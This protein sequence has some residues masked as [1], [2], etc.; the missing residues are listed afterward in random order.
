M[1]DDNTVRQNIENE[2][3]ASPTV[4]DR[5]LLVKVRDG[6]A[7][8]GGYVPH[9]SD[10]LGALRIASAADGVRAVADLMLSRPEMS[11]ERSDIDIAVAILGALDHCGELHDCEIKPSVHS[12]KVVLSGT[13]NHAY[14]REIAERAAAE[15]PGVH[16][17]LTDIAIRPPTASANVGSVKSELEIRQEC[18]PV[19]QE[20]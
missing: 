13:V 4:D 3:Q 15:L 14:Q 10:R 9:L 7:M 16:Q 6:I 18:V 5:E 12:G 19:P 8:L 1:S 2:L 17:V 11:E 20:A